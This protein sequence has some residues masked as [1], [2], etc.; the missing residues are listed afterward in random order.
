MQ[1]SGA[2]GQVIQ[3][4]FHSG[5][6]SDKKIAHDARQSQQSWSF[7]PFH[8]T[9]FLFSVLTSALRDHA[10]L[11]QKQHT[12]CPSGPAPSPAWQPETQWS[13]FYHLHSRSWSCLV[14]YPFS[15]DVMVEE[16]RLMRA[17]TKVLGTPP[18]CLLNASQR[19]FL[20]FFLFVWSAMERL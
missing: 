11:L 18:T 20:C 8:S 17:D 15:T 5:P 14:P 12:C 16:D 2:A 4:V 6:S 3:P 19:S 10:T 9:P 7:L 13:T 1:N